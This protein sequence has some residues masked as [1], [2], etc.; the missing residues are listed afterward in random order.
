MQPVQ[1][2]VRHT[3]QASQVKDTQ[4]GKADQVA[5]TLLRKLATLCIRT[6]IHAVIGIASVNRCRLDECNQ[7]YSILINIVH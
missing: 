2:P 6:Y 5:E 3:R 7:Y 1:H 4:P